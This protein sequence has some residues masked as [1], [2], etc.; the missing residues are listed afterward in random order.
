MS[1]MKNSDPQAFWHNFFSGLYLAL[2]VL[3][4]IYLDASRK[5]TKNI[6]LF[7]FFLLIL[8][9]FRLIRLFVYDSVTGHIRSYFGKFEKGA[10]K[11]LS[12][13]INCP[14]CTGI[15]MGL[16]VSS[17]YF[18]TPFS[19]FFIFILALAGAGSSFQIIMRRIGNMPK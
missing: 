2:V 10:R 16:F 14:W 5:L 13:L 15:W 9:T 19:W 11:E 7:D 12:M 1:E 4:T 8:A 6:P 3:V 18:L 17:I